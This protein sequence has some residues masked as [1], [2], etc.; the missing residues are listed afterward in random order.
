MTRV[1]SNA[2][3]SAA[4]R[5]KAAPRT[6]P[7][8]KTGPPRA[9]VAVPRAKDARLQLW[10]ACAVAAT[11]TCL[12]RAR[13]P[14]RD[15]DALAESLG[16]AADDAHVA[17][18][19]LRWEPSRGVL[20]DLLF[21]RRL[22]F[23][24]RG[25]QD[26]T[27]D[28]WR[29]RVRVTPDGSVIDVASVRD[30]TNTPLGDDHALVL[31]GE[32]AAFATRAYGQEQSVT[33]LD[34]AGE[35]AQ[36]KTTGW[37]SETMAAITN[38]QRTGTASG[39]GRVDV[40]FDSPGRAVSLELGETTLAITLYGGDSRKAATALAA[41][42]DLARGELDAAASGAPPLGMHAD[43]SMHLPK[44]FSHWV[45][46]TLRAVSW[47]G[48]APIAWLEDQVLAVRDSYR[49]ATFRATAGQADVIATPDP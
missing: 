5:A 45:V 6:P 21:G 23:L 28:V 10:V 2:A 19:D 46:D 16:N 42:V 7:P 35:G 40:T 44:R 8:A 36:N 30:L 1:R 31:R 3:A 37:L 9:K 27:R 12:F 48:P 41:S 43:P 33:V 38:W 20:G 26:E 4:S 11:V 49:R 14:G 24:A 25:K 34:L 15:L 18:E 47:I 29:A 22:L 17:T 39:I 32:H 13:A